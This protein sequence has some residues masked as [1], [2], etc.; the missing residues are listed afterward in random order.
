MIKYW[1]YKIKKVGARKSV[2]TKTTSQGRNSKSAWRSLKI[3]TVELIFFVLIYLTLSKSLLL[4][5]ICTIDNVTSTTLGVF[6]GFY[7]L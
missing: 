4:L 2:S 5:G 1:W 6:Y 7:F 3:R